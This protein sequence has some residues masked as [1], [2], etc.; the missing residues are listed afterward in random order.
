V[1]DTLIASAIRFFARLITAIRAESRGFVPDLKP[2]VYFAN[3][4][5]NADFVLIWT[6]LPDMLRKRTRPVAAADYWNKSWPRRYI[7]R[8]VFNAVLIERVAEKR[9]E[10]PI[11]QMAAAL[12]EGSSLILFPEGTR[13][14]GEAPLLPFKS[15]LY[16]LAMARPATE[17]VPVW[18]ANLNRVMPK[19]ERVPVPLLCTVSF[20]RPV[21]VRGGESKDEFL[22]RA[23]SA[24]LALRPAGAS[25]S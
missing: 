10:D 4:C 15:G 11:A 7:G 21:H 17:L 8:R 2:R 13:N 18:I 24:L 5:S 14:L 6:A 12:D 20:G 23:R 22:E 16:W 1:I 9:S 3:H 25:R 19:G